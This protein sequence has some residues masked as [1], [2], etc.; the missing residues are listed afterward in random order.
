MPHLQQHT[1]T[2]P[3]APP[4]WEYV[5]SGA[6][7]YTWP[8]NKWKRFTSCHRTSQRR[9]KD[10]L[11]AATA[12]R[13]GDERRPHAGVICCFSSSPWETQTHTLHSNTCIFVMNPRR[14]VTGFKLS[15]TTWSI[16]NHL[17]QFP[18]PTLF[19][20]LSFWDSSWPLSSLSPLLRQLVVK[21]F[22]SH[23]LFLQM[24]YEKASLLNRKRDREREMWMMVFMHACVRVLRLL[25]Q[26]A[27]C[28]SPKCIKIPERV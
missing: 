13:G 17:I 22:P 7:L 6:Q 24:N 4:H 8:T 18:P 12:G 28:D 10:T 11:T 16:A 5:S 14:P 9:P 19:S 23:F 27:L 20:P 21:F 1:A 26:Y 25:C 2:G 3:P 15:N